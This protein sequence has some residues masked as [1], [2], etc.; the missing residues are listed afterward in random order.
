MA[1]TTTATGYV[2]VLGGINEHPE[3]LPPVV[4]AV[5][6]LETPHK[7]V[8]ASTIPYV[9]VLTANTNAP[10]HHD[11]AVAH[12]VFP[13][14]VTGTLRTPAPFGTV[15]VMQA[16]N[17][18]EMTGLYPTSHEQEIHLH[19]DEDHEGAKLVADEKGIVRVDMTFKQEA[20]Q[21]N[22]AGHA[23]AALEEL[24]TISDKSKYFKTATDGPLA[25]YLTTR[26]RTGGKPPMTVRVSTK[27]EG[28]T[29]IEGISHSDLKTVIAGDLEHCVPHNII[30]VGANQGD[31]SITPA[32]KVAEKGQQAVQVN[33]VL[34]IPTISRKTGHV[35]MRHT[36]GTRQRHHR[37][38][39]EPTK[40]AKKG[41]E[42]DAKSSSSD[43][44]GEADSNSDNEK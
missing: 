12:T 9:S 36:H 29:K 42:E 44:D 30:F 39:T 37:Y 10:D 33:G 20:F 25:T 2:P 41:D 7:G 3:E 8:V 43:D 4:S 23:I 6:P 35:S 18:R 38:Q 24:G 27:D 21:P 40:R 22:N 32:R 26:A 1:D 17:K 5:H 19:H 15:T 14:K 34:T 16:A 13:K 31:L 28:I 11:A